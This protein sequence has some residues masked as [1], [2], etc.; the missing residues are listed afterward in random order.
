[1]AIHTFNPCR[2]SK[3]M[4][5]ASPPRKRKSTSTE[6]LTEIKT[7]AGFNLRKVLGFFKDDDDTNKNKKKFM[8]PYW[9][10][11]IA[12]GLVFASSL[13][14]GFFCCLYG[15][16]FGKEKSEQWLSS[17]MISFWQS[18]I[19]I[20]PFKVFLIAAFIALI[21]KDP[22]KEEDDEAS[23]ELKEDE[24]FLQVSMNVL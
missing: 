3:A 18:V 1:M 8:F 7:K 14:S 9:C 10:I 12:Y 19:V 20:Q 6:E 22:E 23:A 16:Q 2:Q 21:V 4:S 5:I 24:Q 15:F 13:V 11:Y 17:M